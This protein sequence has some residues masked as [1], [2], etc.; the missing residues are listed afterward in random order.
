VDTNSGVVREVTVGRAP[1]GL[2][3]SP[4][5][6]TLAVANSHSDSITLVDTV[7]LTATPVSI[8]TWPEGLLGS[9]PVAVAFAPKGDSG[10][11]DRYRDV[12]ESSDLPWHCDVEPVQNNRQLS[13]ALP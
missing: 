3:L 12:H 1:T 2:A 6:L 8:P 4:D 11:D 9:E 5:G 10:R 7:K 13:L